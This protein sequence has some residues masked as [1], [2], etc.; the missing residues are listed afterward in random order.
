MTGP[1]VMKV[2]AVMAAK[3]LLAAKAALIIVGSV[4]LKK[5]FERDH[6]EPSVKVHTISHDEEDHDRVS[7]YGLAGYGYDSKP[8][9][10]QYYN[11]P[12]SSYYDDYYSSRVQ[13]N[14]K[15]R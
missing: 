6:H 11:S 1:L 4:A 3:A 7:K 14:N 5:L 9:S 10:W 13:K 8:D 15:I 12:Y 2:L